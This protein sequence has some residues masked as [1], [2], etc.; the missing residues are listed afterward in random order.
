MNIINTLL[1]KIERSKE[2]DFGTIF[3][4]SIELFKKT[5][6]QG[7][8]LQLFTIIIMLPL[9]I[10]LYIPL[11]GM[12][13][14]QQEN[15]YNNPESFDAFFAGMSVLYILFVIVGIFVLGAISVALNAGFYRIMK[16]LDY[17]EQVVTSDFFYFIKVKYLS[18]TFILMLV[19]ILIAVPAAL[20]C[21]IPLIYA[22]VPLSY[23]ALI[24]A[25]NP[26]LSVGDIVKLSFKLGNKKWLI[27]FGL[28]IV[29]SLL[30]QIV[31][32]IMCFIGVLFTAA[33]VYHPTYLIYKKVIGFNDQTAIDEIGTT[34]E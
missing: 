17:N 24:F 9:I 2:L 20:L 10:V 7:F 28:I 18:K 13:I 19:T 34:V 33:F 32:F 31:G 30:A 12:V 21:Y 26:E 1:E 16:K 8:L 29:S 15:G 23:F 4:E 22:I 5:W 25:F 11:I 3:N 14:A 27:S 6:L